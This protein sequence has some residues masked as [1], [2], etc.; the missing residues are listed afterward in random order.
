MKKGDR[1][2]FLD[3]NE[4]AQYGTVLGM[5]REMKADKSPEFSVDVQLVSTC[6]I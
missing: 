2:V 3:D 6:R 4:Q 5:K 1:V